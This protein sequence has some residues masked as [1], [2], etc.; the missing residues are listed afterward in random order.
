MTEVT[1]PLQPPSAEPRLAELALIAR[2]RSG[3]E[4]AFGELVDRQHATLVRLALQYVASAA[5]ESAME[6]YRAERL[7]QS[8]L[9]AD[10]LGLSA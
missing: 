7:E 10:L 3:D 4:V 8:K 9:L 1:V 6:G 5:A 2:L